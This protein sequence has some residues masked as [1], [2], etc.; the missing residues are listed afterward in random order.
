[1]PQDILRVGRQ[2]FTGAAG[3]TNVLRAFKELGRSI[4]GWFFKPSRPN[5]EDN[6]QQR[7]SSRGNGQGRNSSEKGDSLSYGL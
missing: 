1:M 2:P 6:Q 3:G 4:A 5:E 7:Y